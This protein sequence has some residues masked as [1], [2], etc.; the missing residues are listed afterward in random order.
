MSPPLL[1]DLAGRRVAVCGHR[2]MAGRAIVRRLATERCEIVTADHAAV[3][4]TQ[5]RQ[6]EDWIAREKPDALFLAAAR[7]GGIHANNAYPAD[8]SPTTW[9]S[10]STSCAPRWRIA[11]RSC[12][13]SVLPAS[14]RSSRRSR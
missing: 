11:S 12:C 7:V 10:R 3:D 13:S 2:G 8:F 1:F 14:I 9:R 5:Q 4:L 6:T